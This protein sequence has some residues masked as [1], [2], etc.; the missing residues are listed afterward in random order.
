MFLRSFVSI[1]SLLILVVVATGPTHGADDAAFALA[2]QPG[3]HLDVTFGGRVVAR[4]MT[5]FDPERWDETARPYLHVMDAAG[6]KPITKGPGGL[7]PH[8]RGIFIGYSRLSVDG[9]T[10]NFW[11]MGGG[12]QVHQRFIDQQAGPDQA[13]FTSLVHW[14]T[15]DEQLLIEEQRTFLFRTVGEPALVCV[16]VDSKLTAVAA[17]I[18]LG[19]DPEHAGV[20]YRPADELDKSLTRYLFPAEDNDPRRDPDL[21]WVALS[22]VLDDHV[23][24]VVQMNHPDNPKQSIWSAY[25]DYG[26]FGA[27]PQAEIA[28]GQSLTLRYQFWILQGELPDRQQIQAKYQQYAP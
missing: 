27:F 4:Y 13:R 15:K 18:V 19:G 24:G 20:Q 12:P 3:E 11:G 9:R 1:V 2:E 7:F 14:K 17:D 8:H 23:Y 5:V 28:R 22:Y 21:P 10:Y 16:Q 25:R 26:R 6:Q